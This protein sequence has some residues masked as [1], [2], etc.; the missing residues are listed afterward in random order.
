MKR[1]DIVFVAIVVLLYVFVLWK[2]FFLIML[3]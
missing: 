3:D 2:L 1:R